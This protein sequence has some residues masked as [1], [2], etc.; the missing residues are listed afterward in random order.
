MNG[1]PAGGDQEPQ[2]V[3]LIFAY[4]GDEVRLESRQPVNMVAPASDPVEG[5]ENHMGFWTEV[6]DAQ[7]AVLHRQ[8]LHDPVRRDAEVF[9]PN[10]DRSIRRVP[11]EQPSGMFWVVVPLVPGADHVSLM[12]AAGP[13]AGGFAAPG[14]APMA[15]MLRVSLTEDAES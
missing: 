6:R 7:G 8:I 4:D 15:E 5:F 3:R 2:S 12:G 13:G 9:S 1:R 14:L 10:P 11:D